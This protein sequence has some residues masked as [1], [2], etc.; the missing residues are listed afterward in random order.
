MMRIAGRRKI[1]LANGN[2][3]E[4]DNDKWQLQKL[5]YKKR[6]VLEGSIDRLQEHMPRTIDNEKTQ[7]CCKYN[8]LT[9]TMQVN[10]GGYDPTI[11]CRC[12]NKSACSTT[13]PAKTGWS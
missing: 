4:T 10:K 13:P 1:H 3:T 7:V 12:P 9:A 11:M 2:Q 5:K 8:N 6:N